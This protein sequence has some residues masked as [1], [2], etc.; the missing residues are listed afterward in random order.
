M[1]KIFNRTTQYTPYQPEIAQ[2]RLESLLN[3]QTMIC[4][5]TG[6]EVANASLLDEGTAAAEALGL[7]YRH[8]KRKILFVSD[9]VHPQTISVIATRANSL[10]LTLQVGDVFNVDTSS[11]QVAGIL[12]QYPDTTGAIYDYQKV[13]DKAHAD[14]VSNKNSKFI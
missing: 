3:Y 7:A 1:I 2:G 14:G 5:M 10:G 11:K 4:D 9:K 8:N 6:M 12:L 13:V